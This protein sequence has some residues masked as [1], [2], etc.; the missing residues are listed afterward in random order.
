MNATSHQ[1]Q[2]PSTALT[3]SIRR[4]NAEASFQ[5]A[6]EADPWMALACYDL[7]QQPSSR[8]L[9]SAG[10]VGTSRPR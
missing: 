2:I 9:S 7:I 6:W 1:A 10:S 8:A 5:Q 4:L 3:D